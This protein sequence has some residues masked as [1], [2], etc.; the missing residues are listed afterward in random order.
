M[1]AIGHWLIVTLFGEAYGPAYTALLALL[2][3]LFGLCYA[4][5]LRLDLLGKQR[6]GALSLLLA[7]GAILNLLLNALL[8]PAMGIV[9]AGLASSIAY[10]AV[11]LAMLVM[12]CKLSGVA[13]YRTLV[14]LPEDIAH[15]K[16]L[17]R[18]K[19]GA[20]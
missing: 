7:G 16:Q 3:G 14:V 5:I 8:I 2:P 1:A 20:C 12:Y 17:I 15:L 9:G 6:P 19:A 11:S 18:P 4:S 10:L 13:W